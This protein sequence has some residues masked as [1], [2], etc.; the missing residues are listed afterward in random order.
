MIPH[1][2]RSLIFPFPSS[3]HRA[4][5]LLHST[6]IHPY[7]ESMRFIARI[8]RL[9][10]A[11]IGPSLQF[12]IF[13]LPR[14]VYLRS[15]AINFDCP[16]ELYE[17]IRD[18]K[19]IKQLVWTRLASNV[20]NPEQAQCRLEAITFSAVRN[21]YIPA[22]LIIE[23]ASTL[24]SLSVD[25]QEYLYTLWG[26]TRT[27]PFSNLISF[28][29]SGLNAVVE[30]HIIRDILELCPSL[31]TLHL[32]STLHNHFLLS[33][34]ALPRL[35]TLNAGPNGFVLRFVEGRPVRRL[36]ANPI[37]LTSF[38]SWGHLLQNC[39]FSLLHVWI[40]YTFANSFFTNLNRALIHCEDLA[41]HVQIGSTVR[42]FLSFTILISHLTPIQPSDVALTT[43][44]TWLAAPNLVDFSL[45]VVVTAGRSWE[46]GSQPPFRMWLGDVCGGSP[47]LQ[48][49]TVKYCRGLQTEG[50][51]HARRLSDG[52]WVVR[53]QLERILL[54][55]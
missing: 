53:A 16:A 12:I 34:G 5:R 43:L 28:T 22:G 51:F 40:E 11:R 23:S 25:S 15:L 14:M 1:L 31:T 17:Y 48:Q 42:H 35:N 27:R 10:A 19:Q 36:F 21:S 30:P 2:F 49:L 3:V 26:L 50:N 9:D 4:S 47:N 54:R 39:S 24:K 37:T 38:N 52:E 18:S 46:I 6:Y 20:N 44:I 8:P 41:V 33:P 45:T 7:V 32:V 55:T 13:A 29:F